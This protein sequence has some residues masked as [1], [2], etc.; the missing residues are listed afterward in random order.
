MKQGH[1]LPTVVQDIAEIALDYRYTQWKPAFRIDFMNF[2]GNAAQAE[3]LLVGDRLKPKTR[4]EVWPWFDYGNSSL[5]LAEALELS[6][7]P[8]YEVISMNATLPDGSGNE[9]MIKEFMDSEYSHNIKVISLG[10]NAVNFLNKEKIN[11]HA[12]LRHPQYYR[13]FKQYTGAEDIRTTFNWL[14]S[15]DG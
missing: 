12:Y 13:R 9:Y 2:T 3:Y 10:D 7:V 5:W 4:R 6:H 14:R 8:E 11:V 1:D 15:Q